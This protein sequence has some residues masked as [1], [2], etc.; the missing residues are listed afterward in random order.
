MRIIRGCKVRCV[1][2]DIFRKFLYGCVFVWKGIYLIGFGVSGE[3]SEY[4][5][6]I[7]E[8]VNGR[9]VKYNLL[10]S[11]RKKFINIG[12]VKKYIK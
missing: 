7:Y 6:F 4:V 12:V 9:K 1:S 2:L 3:V 10:F 11:F 5:S 8:G